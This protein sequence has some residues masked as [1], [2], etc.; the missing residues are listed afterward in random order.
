MR[1]AILLIG[2]WASLC[3][4]SA[5]AESPTPVSVTITQF[6]FESAEITV[7][8][9]TTVRWVNRDETVH[10]V[11]SRDGRFASGGLDTGDSYQFTF[12]EPGDF[13]YLCALHPHMTGI[14]HVQARPHPG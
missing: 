1:R 5:Q 7:D 11:V 9:G 14:I 6:K 8:A 3:G 2:L 4:A 13:A 12:A 10:N